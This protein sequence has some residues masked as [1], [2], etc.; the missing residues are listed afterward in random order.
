MKNILK[1]IIL[2]LLPGVIFAIHGKIVFYD[3]TYVVGKVTKVDESSVYIVPIG[4]DTPEGV[5][6]G[7][8]DS[9]KMENGMIPIV[10]SAVKYFYQNGEFMANDDDW[11]DEYNDFQYDDFALLQEEYKYEGSKRTPQQYYQL[12]AS[13]GFP[14]ISAA[15]LKNSEKHQGQR[16]KIYLN[17]T[18]TIRFPYFQLGAVDI[19]PGFRLMNYGFEN[20]TNGQWK[21]LQAA[22]FASVDFKPVFYFLPKSIHLTADAGLSYNVSF[23]SDQDTLSGYFMNSVQPGKPGQKYGGIG[24]NLGGSI[25]YWMENLPIALRIFGNGYFIPQ[26]PPWPELKTMFGSVGISVV[27]ILKRHRDSNNLN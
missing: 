12:S 10:N 14:V 7:N 5:L 16:E 21:C 2:Q 19:S 1:A 22:F 13:G 26:P 8:I 24:F 11:M 15:S 3:G 18:G 27:V 23:D 20:A 4:L 6:V 9:L 25:D 17:L